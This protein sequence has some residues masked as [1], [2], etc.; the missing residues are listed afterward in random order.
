M[1]LMA[2]YLGGSVETILMRFID[3]LF[4]FPPI[5]TGI[6]I[7]TVLGPGAINVAYALAIAGL[8][9]FARLTRSIVLG[10]KH[11]DYVLSARALGARRGRIM[12]RHILPNSLGPLLVQLALFMGIAVLA[13]AGLSFLGLGTQPPLP[14]WGGMLSTSQDYLRTDFWIAIW[15]GIALAL[16]VLGLNLLSDAMREALDPRR[17]NV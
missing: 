3:T 10:E 9:S 14:S 15:P 7:L 4:A 2:G 17:V 8:P 16:L 5:L 13:E 1:G 12:F 6:A 11:R